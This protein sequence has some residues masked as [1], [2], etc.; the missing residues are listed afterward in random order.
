MLDLNRISSINGWMNN[1]ELQW[2]YDTAS[3]MGSVLEIGAWCG[4]STF[5]LC[6]GCPG[7]V[8]SID[9]FRGSLEHE[10]LIKSGMNPIAV[11]Y[12]NMKVF[13][14]IITV[15]GDSA[16][17]SK[18]I[19]IGYDM[20]FIDGA[21]EKEAIEKDLASWAWN[22]TILVAG[23]DWG[24]GQIQEAVKTFFPGAEIKQAPGSLWYTRRDG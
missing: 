6:S 20:L 16:K 15:I 4:R 11:Y 13:G 21:H 9:H 5:A 19:A 23:H 10:G 18:H 7:M 1:E 8:F 2:L 22:A 12:E 14:N 3:G 17:V 24:Y